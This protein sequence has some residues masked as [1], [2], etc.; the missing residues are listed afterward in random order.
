V[1]T[2]CGR[3]FYQVQK[4]WDDGEHHSPRG[5]DDAFG[6]TLKFYEPIR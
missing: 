1:R 6:H 4:P 5:V 3:E 2:Q